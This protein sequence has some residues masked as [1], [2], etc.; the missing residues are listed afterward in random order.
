[1]LAH[2]L[3]NPLAPIRNALHVL[4]QPGADGAH[5]PSRRGDMIERQVQHMARL[6]DD[7]LDVSRISRGRI[8]LRKEAV[9]AGGGRRPRGGGRPPAARGRRHELTVVAAGRAAA[10]GGRPDPAGAGARPTC[11]T[12]P[13]S[14]PSRAGTIWLTAERDGGEAVLRV[15]DTGIGIAPE[16]LPRSLRPVRAG[17]ARG[18]T[19]RRA[20]WASA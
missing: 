8:E 14:T 12:T 7:L 5:A 11:S 17:R 20:A 13:P 4:R 10:A 3:R 9:D 1:M 15:R 19:A 6:V 2:E 16:M 18:W